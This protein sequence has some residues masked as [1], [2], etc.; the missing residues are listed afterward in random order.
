MQFT[1][2]RLGGQGKGFGDR[3]GEGSPGSPEGS[4]E[5]T[6]APPT[7]NTGAQN[8]QLLPDWIGVTFKERPLSRVLELFGRDQGWQETN[9]ARGYRSGLVRGDVKVWHD[10]APGMGVHVEVSGRGCRQL[11]VRNS[12]PHP[13]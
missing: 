6:A 7:G 4:P 11:E 12:P 13:T 2:R 5:S 1:E 9:G 8:T 3:V 10:G